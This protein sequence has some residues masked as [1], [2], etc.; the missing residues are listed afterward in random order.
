MKQE[1]IKKKSD[2]ELDKLLTELK[3][4][5]IKASSE[6]GRSRVK[7]KEAGVSD[8]NSTNKGVKTSLRKNIRKN[9]AR[10]LTEINSRKKEVKNESL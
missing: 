1:E 2:K 7:N 9:I 6:W 3:F 10:I 4:I 8:S 5:Q